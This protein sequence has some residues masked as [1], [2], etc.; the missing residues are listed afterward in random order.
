ITGIEDAA[1]AAATALRVLAVDGFI[2]M[3]AVDTVALAALDERWNRDPL[4]E[5]LTPVVRSGEVETR[6]L[7]FLSLGRLATD[8]SG[9]LGRLLEDRHG[10]AD[11]RTMNNI[12]ASELLDDLEDS[13]ISTMTDLITSDANTIVEQLATVHDT[14]GELTAD[15]L[16][17]LTQGAHYSQ[18]AQV[19]TALRGGDIVD[20][21]RF[22]TAG[23]NPDYQYAHAQNLAFFAA[24]LRIALKRTADD[25][26][27]QIG[28]ISS[29][30]G[31]ASGLLGVAYTPISKIVGVAVAIAGSLTEAEFLEGPASNTSDDIDTQ[32][33]YLVEVIETRF[34]PQYLGDTAPDRLGDARWAWDARWDIFRDH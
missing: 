31:M 33:E 27:R 28:L 24:N 7:A 30:A 34:Q 1:V 25:A 26:K 18:L 20:V 21:D 16:W 11:E 5:L 13:L 19:A 4:R 10:I 15:Y 2:D 22:S 6:T 9:R 29:V 12:R 23:T 14:D 3:L 32:L 17:R 8:L